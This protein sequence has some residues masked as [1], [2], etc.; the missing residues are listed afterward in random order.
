MA[1]KF[2]HSFKLKILYDRKRQSSPTVHRAFDF[3]MNQSRQ[4]APSLKRLHKPFLKPPNGV[5]R[6]R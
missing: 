2:D 3:A 5:S 1:K 4:Q 6:I